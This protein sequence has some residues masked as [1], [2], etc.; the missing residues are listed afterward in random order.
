MSLPNSLRAY[1]DCAELFERAT[2]DPKG[3]RACVGTYEAGINLRTRMHY[4]RKLDRKANESVY[5]PSNPNH[6]Q[7]IYDEYVIPGPI[8]D[9]DGNYWLYIEPRRGKILAIEGLSEVG[10]LLEVEGTEVHLIEDKS[11]G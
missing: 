5:P 4:Y 8:P 9:Q 2:L 1:G 11:N 10:D 7:S 3:A 6:G